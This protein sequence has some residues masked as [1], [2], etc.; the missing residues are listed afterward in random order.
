M[1]FKTRHEIAP[2][3]SYQEFRNTKNPEP[4][5]QFAVANV[6][7]LETSDLEIVLLM[8]LSHFKEQ[9][10]LLIFYCIEAPRTC[11]MREAFEWGNISWTDYWNHKPW[12]I[13]ITYKLG[14]HAPTSRYITP[15]EIVEKTVRSFDRLGHRGPYILKYEQ[16]KGVFKYSDWI[17]E[18]SIK[19]YKEFILRHGERLRVKF[20]Q[21]FA[22]ESSEKVSA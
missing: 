14:G 20:P 8:Y 5:D 19:D 9:D 10:G 16:L 11:P 6:R 22:D 7:E 3:W 18:K 15:S 13:E 2:Q 4:H 1:D 21:D 17:T 12:L